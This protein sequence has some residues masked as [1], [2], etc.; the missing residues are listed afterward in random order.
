MLLTRSKIKRALKKNA[1]CGF[2]FFLRKNR[3]KLH[4]YG[5]R[6][7][8]LQNGTTLYPELK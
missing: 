3:A 8:S 4:L 7:D 1:Q 2:K 6:K 5:V